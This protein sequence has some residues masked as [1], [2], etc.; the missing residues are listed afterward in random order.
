MTEGSGVN[1]KEDIRKETLS[2]TISHFYFR[3]YQRV[4]ELG[5]MHK[6]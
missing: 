5:I 3:V 4:R 6:I 1:N 2:Q